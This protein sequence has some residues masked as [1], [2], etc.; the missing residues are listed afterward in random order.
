MKKEL[1]EQIQEAVELSL[2]EH[3]NKDKKILIDGKEVMFG[4]DDHI[5]DLEKTLSGLTR[6]RDCFPRGSANR[7]RYSQALSHLKKLIQT[8]KPAPKPSEVNC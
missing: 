8:L 5:S 1:Q 4:S 2:L 7:H 6:V 3:K